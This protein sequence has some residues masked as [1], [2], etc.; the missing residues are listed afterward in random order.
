[1]TREN[2]YNSTKPGNLFVGYER[3]RNQLLNG[4]RNGNSFAVLG[5]VAAAKPH[6]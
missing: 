4:F 2:P 6:C 3:L 5:G 1:M